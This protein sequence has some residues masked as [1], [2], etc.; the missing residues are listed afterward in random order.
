MVPC[1]EFVPLD[2]A[3]V[4]TKHSATGTDYFAACYDQHVPRDADLF[5]V[6]TAI[7]DKYV[8]VYQS[9]WNSSPL[10]F[11]GMSWPTKAS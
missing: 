1:R 4:L 2:T 8:C 11:P 5:V 7:N 3:S 6:E 10:I 9:L